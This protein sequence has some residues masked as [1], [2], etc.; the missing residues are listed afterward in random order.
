MKEYVF[1]AREGYCKTVSL[2]S[3][4]KEIIKMA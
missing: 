1:H 2:A 3:D 4:K